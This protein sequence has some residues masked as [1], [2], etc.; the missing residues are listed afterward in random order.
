MAAPGVP[1]RFCDPEV[2]E[3]VDTDWEPGDHAYGS[4]KITFPAPV[5]ET[6]YMSNGIRTADVNDT[7]ELIHDREEDR[8]FA[9]IAARTRALHA[10]RH[11]PVQ[12][13]ND[14]RRQAVIQDHSIGGVSGIS[15]FQGPF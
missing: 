14:D 3:V 5:Q 4:D 9:Y 1:V 13:P 15:C 2:F 6:L 8:A 11:T 12:G 7:R 10:S